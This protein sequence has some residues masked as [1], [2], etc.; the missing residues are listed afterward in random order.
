MEKTTTK[1][2]L[3]LGI[4][5]ELHVA[6]SRLPDHIT[7]TFVREC[8][9]RLNAFT[10]DEV[11]A[12]TRQLAA[13]GNI[14]RLSNVPHRIADMCESARKRREQSR[15][16]SVAD[17]QQTV[18]CPKCQ[19]TGIVTTWTAAALRE[20]VEAFTYQ[21]RPLFAEWGTVTWRCPCAAGDDKYPW[22]KTFNGKL[23]IIA[24]IKR[25]GHI[26]AIATTSEPEQ[27]RVA[28]EWCL[29]KPVECLPW[30]D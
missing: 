2:E 17:G 16:R 26:V 24:D 30:A 6:M 23:P 7:T 10:D 25:D 22:L 19:D 11:V 3:V 13:N 27:Q 21:R 12:A 28:L 8:E 4:I 1:L 15:W 18:G 9:Q 14:P 20:L 5:P 29:R